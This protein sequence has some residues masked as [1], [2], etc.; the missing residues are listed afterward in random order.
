M[1]TLELSLGTRTSHLHPMLAAK[2]VSR[3]CVIGEIKKRKSM[4]FAVPMVWREG[5]DHVSDCYFC[6]TNLK[7]VNRKNKHCIQYPNVPSA[8]RPV[9][10][11]PGLPVPEPDVAME[12]SSESESDNAL[13]RAEGGEYMPEENDRPVP[14]TQADLNDLTRDLNLS[15]ESAQLLGS[16]LREKNLLAPE[17]TF[18]W[19]RE[20]ER[21]FRQF[22]TTQKDSSLV[23]CNNIAGLI[24]SMGLD[25]VAT[26]WRLF[27]DSSSRSLKA[28]LLHNGNKY[29][30][31][32][33]G[34][35]V[36]MKETHDNMDQL[37][38]AL[39]YN[40]HG[41][42]ICGDLKVVGLVLGLQGGYTKYPCFLCLWDSRA[43]DQHFVRQEWPPRQRLEPGSHNVQARSLVE[44]NKVL[45]PSL[46]IKLGL[47]KNF[48]KAM[49][50]DGMGF[51]FLQLKFPRISLEKLKAG[52]FDGPQIREL[53]KDSMFD[54]A[55]NAAELSVWCSLKS[56][57]RNFLGNNRS[58][59]YEKEVDELLNSYQ[60]LGARM[61]VKMHFLRSHLDYF[62][63]NC[64]DFSE[65]QG[66]RFHQD[67]SVMEERYQ[68][69][70]DV[71]FLADYCWCLKRDVVAAQH[72]RK[73]LKRPFIHD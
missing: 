12:S 35:S 66:E 15:K 53:M 62:P 33:I 24:Q 73:S 39:N 67:I 41:W 38:S 49:D 11:G 9:P 68:G 52:I 14:L 54:D 37:L 1:L 59:E 31:I 32:P 60:K 21:E 16:R 27:I 4:P 17:T 22:F 34:H 56:V 47:M 69:R 72:R 2:H 48:V 13:D 6:M 5:K 7:G 61:S 26:E 40:D 28:V 64:G 45:L 23:Y 71:N 36:Q 58:A 43:D 19:Y 8:I 55:L 3:T 46:H 30:S 57:I 51:T 29:S 70:W 50:K 42:L 18:F 63:Q 25:Y 65:E 20:R 10:H 44:P